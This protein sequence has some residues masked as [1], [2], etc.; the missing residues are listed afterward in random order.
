[1]PGGAASTASVRLPF[2]QSGGAGWLLL[3]VLVVA[4]DIAAPETMSAAF[5]R[6][7]A[8][9]AGRVVV[10]TTWGVITAHLFSALPRAVDP[11]YAVTL[12]RRERVAA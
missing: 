7:T 1:V 10:M 9:P 12:L 8:T 4:W 5:R 11:L 3:T 6:A 2:R